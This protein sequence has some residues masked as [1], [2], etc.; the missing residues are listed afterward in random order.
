MINFNLF[1]AMVANILDV[2]PKMPEKFAVYVDD[3]GRMYINALAKVMEKY[4][5]INSNTVK[6]TKIGSVIIFGDN[7]VVLGNKYDAAEAGLRTMSLSKE[8]EQIVK[9]VEN[10]FENIYNPIPKVCQDCPLAVLCGLCTKVTNT[11]QRRNINETIFDGDFVSM[12]EKVSIFNNFVKIGYDQ[13]NITNLFGVEVVKIEGVLFAVGT[14]KGRK[15][16]SR[17]Y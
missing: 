2:E 1:A 7:N 10:Y 8:Y 11:P 6:N 15:A 4:T 5:S 3:K 16:L 17:I 14:S 13:Y 12:D 9:F